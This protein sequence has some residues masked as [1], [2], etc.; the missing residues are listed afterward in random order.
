METENNDTRLPENF[1]E[2]DGEEI[3]SN[4]DKE[5]VESTAKAIKGKELFSRYSGWNFNGIVW[6]DKIYSKWCCE[7]WCYGSWQDTIV[8]DELQ[9]IMDEVCERWGTD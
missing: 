2:F 1:I 8:A 7:I 5:I 6:W 4:C 3:M 9:D